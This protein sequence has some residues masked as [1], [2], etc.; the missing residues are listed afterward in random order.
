MTE[1]MLDFDAKI[2]IPGDNRFRHS[3]IFA[4]SNWHVPAT[5]V[6]IAERRFKFAAFVHFSSHRCGEVIV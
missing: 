5:K 2:R 1:L 3:S 4:D 6:F